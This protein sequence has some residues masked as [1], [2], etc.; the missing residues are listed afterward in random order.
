MKRFI[1]TTAVNNVAVHAG[2]WGS[3]Q[4]YAKHNNAEIRVVKARYKNP[5]SQR[6]DENGKRTDWY[7]D[8]VLSYLTDREE[9]LSPNLTLFADVAV[10]PTAA[11]ALSNLEVYASETSAIVGHVKRQMLVIPTDHRVPRVLWSTGACTIAKY[12]KSRAGA[13]ARKHHVLGAVVVEV[14]GPK[15]FFVRNVTANA[16]GSFSDLEKKYEPTGVRQNDAAL[17]VTAGDIHVGQDDEDALTALEG[18]VT[19]M[20]PKYLVLHDVLDFDARSHHRQSPTERWERRFDTV[21]A[22]M[23][24]NAAFFKRITP[25]DADEIVVVESNHHEHLMRWL[26]EFDPEKDVINAPFYHALWNDL[27]AF[28]K[29]HGRWPNAYET[30][31]RA[32][33][34]EPGIRFLSREDSLKLAKVEHAMH[35]DKGINGARGNIRSYS[36]LGV[37]VTIGHSHTPGILDGVF[38]TGVTGRLEME[39]NTKPSTW[40]HAHVVLHADGK[41]QLIVTIGP[42]YASP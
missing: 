16:D 4:Q 20:R 22:E 21:E 17:S 7:A 33:G 29:K 38:Q 12:S 34:I 42:N 23:D 27:Y 39:Y 37:K 10:Q 19:L 18:L 30:E 35:G 40:L 13:R 25:W 8:Q 6:E 9:K 36:K 26:K 14:V 5:T 2:F 11:S 41:R 15:K 24:A 32:R 1:I 31:M 28:H 3:I